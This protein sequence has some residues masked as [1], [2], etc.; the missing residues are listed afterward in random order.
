MRPIALLANGINLDRHCMISN[1][2]SLSVCYCVKG[3][4]TAVE[5][6]YTDKRTKLPKNRVYTRK[7]P[8]IVRYAVSFQ[9]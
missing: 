2:E 4:P 1:A 7:I 3:P 8:C 6:Y 9:E 5:E